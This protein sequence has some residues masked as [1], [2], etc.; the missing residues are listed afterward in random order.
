MSARK[1]CKN[2]DCDVYPYYGVAPHICFFRRGKQFKMGQSKLLPR[3]KWPRYFVED[4]SEGSK[5]GY[6][7][8]GTYHCPKCLA[9]VPKKPKRKGR[10]K[11]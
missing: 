2:P 9:G 4:T 7:P 1:P 3:N 6:L 10:G 5:P 11:G 8:C